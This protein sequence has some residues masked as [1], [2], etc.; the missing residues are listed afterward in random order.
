[1]AA[2]VLLAHGSHLNPSSGLPCRAH[3]RALSSLGLF[4]QVTVGFWKEL[5]GLHHALEPITTS[6]IWVVPFFMADGYF[7]RRVLPRELGPRWQRDG[8]LIW[9]EP[10][11]TD[12]RVAQVVVARARALT[13]GAVALDHAAL[14]LIGHGSA[15]SRTSTDSVEAHAEALRATGRFAEVITAYT[16]AEPQVATALSRTRAR[17]VIVV[18]VMTADG[19]HTRETIPD[20]LGLAPGQR[21]PAQIAQR[22]VWLSG[23]IGPDAEMVQVILDRVRQRGGLGSGDRVERVPLRGYEALWR[24]LSVAPRRVGPLRVWRDAQGAWVQH[25]ERAERDRWP[26]VPVEGL[27]AV[28]RRHWPGGLSAESG[29]YRALPWARDLV[30]GWRSGPL[31]LSGLEDALEALLPCAVSAMA[32]WSARGEASVEAWSVYASR[33]RG[34]LGALASIGEAAVASSS[35]SVCGGCAGVPLWLSSSSPVGVDRLPCLRPCSFWAHEA[36]SG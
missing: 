8:S 7:T 31:S 3:A 24:S 19:Y 14:V 11:G 9:C 6:P 25:G 13:A 33:Q 18:P 29:G 23:A 32:S 27:E 16:D 10:V 12:A 15:R 5:P 20:D 35:A 17:D 28:S 22:R 2:L 4:E 30:S 26:V 1:M 34:A 21:A 36:A